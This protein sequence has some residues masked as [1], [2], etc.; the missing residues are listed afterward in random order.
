MKERLTIEDHKK[1]GEML[2]KMYL[3]SM[4]LFIAFSNSYPKSSRV[5][6]KLRTL[7]EIVIQVKSDAENELFRSHP[8]IGQEGLDFYYGAKRNE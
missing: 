4:E 7:H 2:K 1:Y 3:D 6:R 8:E 5:V